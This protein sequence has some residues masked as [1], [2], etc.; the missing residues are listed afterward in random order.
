MSELLFLFE[1][2]TLRTMWAD[3][4]RVA[5]Q[6]INGAECEAIAMA[7]CVAIE[8][9]LTQRNARIEKD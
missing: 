4:R 2:D 3:A 1:T 7:T 5:L 8:I 6:P 9:E